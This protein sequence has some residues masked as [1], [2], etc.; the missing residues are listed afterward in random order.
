MQVTTY[1]K[2]YFYTDSLEN[3]TEFVRTIADDIKRPFSVR[4]NNLLSLLGHF[5]A[6]QVQPL[7]PNCGGVE[8]L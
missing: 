5:A 8:Q 4:F 7:H 3:A 1:Q 6:P 2:Q